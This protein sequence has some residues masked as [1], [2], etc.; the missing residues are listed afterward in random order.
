MLVFGCLDWPVLDDITSAHAQKSFIPADWY[1]ARNVNHSIM[2]I[3]QRIAKRQVSASDCVS[4][5]PLLRSSSWV[6]S[7]VLFWCICTAADCCPDDTTASYLITS[8]LFHTQGY[9]DQSRKGKPSCHFGIQPR[10][11]SHKCLS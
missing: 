7:L 1:C 4:S 6:P 10:Y 5:Q 11:L 2:Y 9:S 3:P 8:T